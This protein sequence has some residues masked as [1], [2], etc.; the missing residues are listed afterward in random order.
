MRS[1]IT[2]PGGPGKP[3]PPGFVVRG[4]YTAGRLRRIGSEVPWITPGNGTGTRREKTR[5][6][7]TLQAHLSAQ[8]TSSA[9]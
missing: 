5:T 8:V 2:D 7:A 1:D 6:S 4:R 3:G 9:G